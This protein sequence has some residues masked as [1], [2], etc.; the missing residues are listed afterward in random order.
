MEM[1]V[2]SHHCQSLAG[3]CK[4]NLRRSVSHAVVNAEENFIW[5]VEQDGI[6]IYVFI[7]ILEKLIS[8][9]RLRVMVSIP[10]S[11][12]LL[13]LQT[14]DRAFVQSHTLSLGTLGGGEAA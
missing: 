11:I 12:P 10:D 1:D 6:L 14:C 9:I 8:S 3:Q 13:I 2:L 4:G 5:H 7:D